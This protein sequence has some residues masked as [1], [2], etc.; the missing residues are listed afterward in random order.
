MMTL[1]MWLTPLP[2]GGNES[3]AM[4]PTPLGITKSIVP[5]PLEVMSKVMLSVLVK[6]ASEALPNGTNR[7]SIEPP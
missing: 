5:S 3:K 6:F 2:K 7:L 1:P 4:L